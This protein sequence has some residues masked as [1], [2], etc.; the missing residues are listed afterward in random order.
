M[1]KIMI[2]LTGTIGYACLIFFL[3][4]PFLSS[5]Q[6]ND[7]DYVFYKGKVVEFIVPYSVGG[8]FDAYARG[9]KPYMEK[10]IPGVTVIIRNVSGAGGLT[11]TNQLY[12]AKGDGLTIGII[13]GAGMVLNQILGAKEA[14]YDLNKMR[15]LGRVYA[16][17]HVLAVR[18]DSPFRSVADL[19]AAKRPVVMAQTG[20]GS[21]DYFLTYL[22]FKALNVPYRDV[23]GFKGSSEAIMAVLRGDQDGYMDSFS[24]LEKVVKEGDMRVIFQ[25]SLARDD[26][27]LKDVPTLLEFIGE[28][29]R[30]M[31]TGITSV[32]AFERPIATP[33]DVS[34]AR[35][36]ALREA[37]WSSLYDPGMIDW[38]KK[39]RPLLP[40][41]GED[42]EKL[43]KQAL[44]AGGKLK[45]L[46][47]ESLK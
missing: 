37:L 13:N 34:Q 29:A 3:I 41:N 10:Y 22:A 26:P 24:T 11:G 43:L 17:T 36:N 23:I 39:V 18:K 46:L 20:K 28:D 31:I 32:F 14:L 38:S 40:L 42:T 4:F 21:D 44:A 27:R 7:K 1:T 45:P 5:V 8:G 30:E 9:L 12:V 47:E 6:A 25:A 16:D 19:K 33:P 15:W 35:V 2:K